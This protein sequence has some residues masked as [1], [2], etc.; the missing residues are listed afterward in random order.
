MPVWPGRRSSKCKACP[1][2]E[3]GMANLPRDKFSFS[4]AIHFTLEPLRAPPK[5]Y[6]FLAG[7]PFL[8]H[9]NGLDCRAW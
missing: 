6:L 9:L 8:V 2:R 4:S 1:R 3:K 5:R 7:E